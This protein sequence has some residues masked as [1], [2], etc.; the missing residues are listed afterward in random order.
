MTDCHVW[1]KKGDELNGVAV[2]REVD[3][4]R[5]WSGFA[6]I[7]LTLLAASSIRLSV[8]DV[9]GRL[10][11]TSTSKAPLFFSG[12]EASVALMTR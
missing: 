1:E 9:Q 12:N 3:T 8:Y 11:G 2:E 6:Q 7:E 4:G 5:V 10:Q